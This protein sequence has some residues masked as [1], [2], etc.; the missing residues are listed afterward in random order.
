MK[1]LLVFF[2]LISALFFLSLQA[3]Q[4][5]KSKSAKSNYKVDTIINK[6]IYQSY[7]SYKYREPIFVAYKLYKGGGDCSREAFHF[8]NDTKILTA[9]DKDYSAS[10]YDKGHLANAE[11][12]ASDCEKQRRTFMFANC[13][14]QMPNLNRGIW[15]HYETYIRKASQIDSLLV[16]AGGFFGKK[17]IGDRVAVPDKCWKVCQSLSTKKFLYILMFTNTDN[18]VCKNVQLKEIEKELGYKLPIK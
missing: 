6:G 7:F 18:A 5:D 9:T 4:P 3:A 12:F 16:I 17:V 14:P 13:L 10:G 2:V 1:S 8:I 15:K 11:D